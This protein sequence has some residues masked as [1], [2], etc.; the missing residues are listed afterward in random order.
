MEQQQPPPTL[1]TD[2]LLEVIA[3]SDD[4]TTVVRCAAVSKPLRRAILDP[5]FRRRLGLRAAATGGFDPDLVTSVSY[6]VRVRLRADIDGTRFNHVVVHPAG[7]SVRFDANLLRSYNPASSREALLVLRRDHERRGFVELLVCNAVTGQSTPLPR[8][9]LHL[10]SSG[11]TRADVY[12]PAL[13][14]TG[15]GGSSFELLVM[16]GHSRMD[17]QHW[18]TQIFSSEGAGWGAARR[19]H[20]PQ[21]V[22]EATFTAPAVIERSVHWLCNSR[23]QQPMVILALHA[24]AAQATVIQLPQ[25]LLASLGGSYA[26]SRPENNLILAATAEGKRLSLVVAEKFVI[27][28]WTLL[29]DE[30]SSSSISSCSRE[31]VVKR[32]EIGRELQF[33]AAVDAYQPI[34]F[35]VFGERSGTVLFWMQEIGLVQLNLGTKKVKLLWKGSSRDSRGGKAFLHEVDL[36]SLL[37]RMKAF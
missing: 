8:M 27:S 25:E 9:D 30:G 18:E 6:R 10:A 14:S 3:R 20:L 26:M 4:V 17:P 37:Q 31:V 36:G 35:E 21:D 29:P 15:G 1:P 13:L 2:P 23:G 33:A 32:R 19:I 28:V 12:C 11:R 22:Q 24:E 34:Q 5:G 7:G 16:Y